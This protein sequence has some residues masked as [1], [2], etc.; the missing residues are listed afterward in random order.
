MP[1]FAWPAPTNSTRW[2]DSRVPSSDVEHDRQAARRIH[3]GA[4]D[5]EGE[6]ADRNAHPVRA[7][8]A[9]AQDAAAVG[10]DD[11]AD[12]RLRPAAQYVA[13]AAALPARDVEAARSLVDAAPFEAGLADRGRVHD[14]QELLEVL[15]QRAEEER[16]VLVPD[17][18]EL[19]EL[20]DRRGLRPQLGEHARDLLRERLGA[21]REQPGDPEAL[22]FVAG[23]RGAPVDQGVAQDL[24]AP[25]PTR[26]ILR[27]TRGSSQRGSSEVEGFCPEWTGGYPGWGAGIRSSGSEVCARSQ[28]ERG[29][30][31]CTES[32]SSGSRWGRRSP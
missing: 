10:H 7:E 20:V 24:D 1:R 26:C 18:G 22:A 28:T 6:L 11:D 16:L 29:H 8:I 30:A 15:D 12:L 9:E 23:E 31:C 17:G 19:D 32:P 5:V 14:R 27:R 25:F 21:R 2:S 3:S 4:R 13:D